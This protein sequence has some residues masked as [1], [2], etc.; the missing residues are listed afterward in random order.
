M[1][2][3]AKHKKYWMARHSELAAVTPVA[4]QREPSV[5]PIVFETSGRLYSETREWAERVLFKNEKSKL[6]S[7]L[8]ACSCLM[9]RRVGG[10]AARGGVAGYGVCSLSVVVRSYKT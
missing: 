7:L 6:S 9:A 4:D 5:V 1:R 10:G 3:K 8:S 2:W